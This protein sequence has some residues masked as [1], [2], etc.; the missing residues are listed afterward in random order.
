MP[1]HIYIRVGQFHDAVVANEKAAKADRDYIRDCAAQGF[2]PGVYYPHNLHFLWWALMF[3]GRS[4]EALRT[5]EQ[6]AEYAGGNYC[7]LSKVLEGPRLRHLPWITRARFGQWDE[8][9]KVP[10]PSATN[11]F[12]VDRAMWHYARGLAFAA[13]KQ[14]DQAAR[15]HAEL[16]ELAHSE[17]AKK[18]DTPQFPATS[19]LAVADQLLAGKVA[20]ARGDHAASIERLERAVAI[21]DAIPYMEP[22]YWPFPTRATLGAAWLQ[23]RQ[24]TKAEQVFRDDLKRLPRNGWGLFGLEQSLRAQ[25][26]NQSADLV[27]R[28]LD[29]AWKRADAKL[30]LAAF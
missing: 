8:V 19:M 28:Q 22:S 7:G 13:R 11:D 18:L 6:A 15:E 9:L 12:L 4:A 3:E 20:G 25:G 27:C 1:S 24:A 21:A 23:A 5:A 29:E 16:S 17:A 14:A 26:K 2:Y 30:E 10:K